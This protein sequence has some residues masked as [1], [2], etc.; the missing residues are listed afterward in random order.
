MT[1]TPETK[2]QFTGNL[3][4]SIITRK[5]PVTTAPIYKGDLKAKGER[6]HSIAPLYWRS[7]LDMA[8]FILAGVTSLVLTILMLVN[9]VGHAWWGIPT[10]LIFWAFTAYLTLP[11][12]HAVMTRIY[13]PDYFIGR[14]RTADG[15]LGDPVN[16]ALIGTEEQIHE[17]MLAAGWTR[18]DDVTLASSWKIV[19]STITRK[20]YAEAPVSPLKIFG[21]IQNFAYQKE[22]DGNPEKRHHVRF[23]K[24]PSGW[25]LP[26][27]ERVDWLGAGT[28][29]S[30]VGF[31]FFTLQVTHRIDAETDYERD[32]I[33]D[34]IQYAFPETE[35]DVLESFSTS[36]H[37]RNGGGDAIITDGNLPVISLR[38]KGIQKKQA[39]SS[40]NLSSVHDIASRL[41]MNVLI[42]A[43]L[44]TITAVSEVMSIAGLLLNLDTLRSQIASEP[45][46][47]EQTMEMMKSE[48][49]EFILSALSWVLLAA[50]IVLVLFQMWLLVRLLRGSSVARMLTLTVLSV[51]VISQMVSVIF[52]G[53]YLPLSVLFFQL[54]ISVFAMLAFTTDAAVAYTRSNTLLKKREKAKKK[55]QTAA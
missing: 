20:S 10:A 13:V 3:R 12:F 39:P 55:A 22:V 24:T 52:A 14:T 25:Q 4:G 40:I 28:Y 38:N 41:P 46:V 32:Y 45:G 1:N 2:E 18:A 35:V 33:V 21:K 31:S 51:G 16:M 36:Y 9:T 17:A 42:G 54:G 23:W 29:D 7:A 6:R 34:E 47:D 27:G 49:G 43:V 11:R 26:G 30:G 44:L 50:V 5:A 53:Q 37:A 48:G 19:V 8:F 15:L